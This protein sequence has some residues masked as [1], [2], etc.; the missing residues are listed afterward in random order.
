MRRVVVLFAAL[1]LGYGMAAAGT[2]RVALAQ[3]ELGLYASEAAYA[4][5]MGERLA[6]AMRSHPDVVVFPEDIGLPLALV[7][8]YELLR[9]CATVADAARTL[10]AADPAALSAAGGKRGWSPVRAWWVRRSEQLGRRYRRVFGTLARQYSVYVVA[11][12][13]RGSVFRCRSPVRPN[14]RRTLAVNPPA[15]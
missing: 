6:E 4:G 15:A 5:H 11:G 14:L 12:S 7:D 2:I 10:I 13:A 1:S 9:N 8:S 3:T